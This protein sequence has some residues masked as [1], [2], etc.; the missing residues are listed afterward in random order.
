MSCQAHG[1]GWGKS[2]LGCFTS[3]R[4]FEGHPNFGG[5]IIF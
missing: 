5:E 1:S 2:V 4:Y 3:V